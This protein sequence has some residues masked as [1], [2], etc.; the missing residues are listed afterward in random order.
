M[1][2]ENIPIFTIGYEGVT[3][4][5]FVQ[6]LSDENIDVLVDCRYR[7]GSRKKGMAKTAL[8]ES[9][10]A[11]GIDYVHD[12]RL[13][14]PPEI[15]KTFR[16]TK[17][18]DWRAYCEFLTHNTTA[19]LEAVFRSRTERIC[20]MCYESDASTCHRRFVARAISSLSGADIVHLVHDTPAQSAESEAD[21]VIRC[22]PGNE[23]KQDP[24]HEA[25]AAYAHKAWS[26]WMD[27]LFSKCEKHG[28][29]SVTMPALSAERW[30]R[31]A[32]T[33]YCDLPEEEK[34]S[35]RDESDKM[36]AIIS[37]SEQS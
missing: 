33:E 22:V 10:K 29:G 35:D 18:Y 14:T 26:G 4:E 15:M 13:G 20:L 6:K 16:E 8:S 36:L 37:G 17:F 23:G 25:L 27:Y 19:V 34:K 28:D 32:Q 9:L 1:Q 3:A 12:R 30:R 11:N 5:E 7:S 2:N 21:R 24:K 31:Q